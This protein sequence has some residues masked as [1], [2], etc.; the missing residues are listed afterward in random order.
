YDLFRIDDDHVI[1]HVHVRSKGGLVLAAEERGSLGCEAAEHD[2]SGVNDE[3]IVLLIG[4]LRRIC[5]SHSVLL[6]FEME[7]FVDPS[8]A[9]SRRHSRHE[10]IGRG[11]LTFG[12]LRTKGLL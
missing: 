4:C 6:S 7:W 2:V 8:P 11:G 3:P 10:C 5:A 1:A 12:Y 9:A